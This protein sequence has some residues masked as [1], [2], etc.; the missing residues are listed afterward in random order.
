M[1]APSFNSFP[2]IFSSFPDLEAGPSSRQAKDDGGSDASRSKH[3]KRT[4]R[5]DDED[6]G[7]ESSR[8]R[9]KRLFV[10]MVSL[11]TPEMSLMVWGS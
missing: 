1:S 5:R 9:E 11:G 8:K 6:V 7:V 2:P 3:S 4:K 10:V